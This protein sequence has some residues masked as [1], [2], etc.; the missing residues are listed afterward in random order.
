[1]PLRCVVFAFILL[2]ATLAKAE[3]VHIP[4]KV[5]GTALEQP[6][7]Y[8]TTLLVMAL[9]ASKAD[10][11]VIDIVF[12]P[13]DYSQARWI[14]MLE[15]DSS[16]FVIWTMTDK[17]RE[18][19]LRPIRIPL[20]KGLFGY[21]VLLIRKHEQARF[22]HIKNPKHLT[23]F[24]GGQGTHWPDTLILQAN[25]LRLT[26]AETTESLFRMINARRFDYFPRGVSEAWFELLQRKETRLEVEDNLLIYY[27]SAI[28]F[29]VN[30]NNEAL[31]QRIEKGMEL[32]IDNGKFDQFFYN[33]PRVSSGLE[34][35]KNR[36]IITLKNPYL[37]AETPV[38]NPRY[39]IDLS[40]L[41]SE[42]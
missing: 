8:F 40:K 7:D 18:Q 1:M 25:G 16:D 6:S 17:E 24:L 42:Q 38:D 37:P 31:A 26:T 13:R 27:P 14:N 12:S 33:H 3:Q 11:E 34:R 2:L 22:D 4:V 19:Q 30:K 36:R 32:L 9:N 28:Y 39:W 15:N 35:L 21:R 10:N 20:F 29:F 41:V 23:K 5:Q